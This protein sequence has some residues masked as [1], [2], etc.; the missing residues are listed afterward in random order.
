MRVG[1]TRIQYSGARVIAATNIDVK[2]AIQAGDF[3][4]DLLYRLN[5][6]PIHLPPLKERGV[7]ILHLIAFYTAERE[8]E[9]G[10]EFSFP[11]KSVM[12]LMAHDWPGNVRELKNV[13]TRAFILADKGVVDPAYIWFE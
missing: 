3:R 10:A 4:Q 7:D 9:L 13:L 5:V 8:K 1:G 6:F 11:H 2:A 12:K